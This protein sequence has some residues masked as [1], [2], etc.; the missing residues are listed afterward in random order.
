[1][2]AKPKSHRRR[3]VEAAET[4][5]DHLEHPLEGVWR[6]EDTSNLADLVEVSTYPT[7]LVNAARKAS[8]SWRRGLGSS[9]H[10]DA[11]GMLR[12]ILAYYDE[13]PK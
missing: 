5:E 2:N 1:M 13:E 3:A 6:S 8:K 9:V 4:W 7:E 10:D 12:A 11:I